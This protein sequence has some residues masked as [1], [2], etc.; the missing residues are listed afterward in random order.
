MDTMIAQLE[1]FIH[2]HQAWSGL[3][4]FLIAF[5]ESLV[6]VGLLIPATAAMVLIGGLIGTGVVGPVPVVVGA[7]LGAICGD[8]VSYV[9]GRKFGPGIVHRKPLRRYRQAVARTRLFFRKYGFAAVFLGRFL[10]PIRSTVPLVA[11]MM[12]MDQKRFQIAN[13]L[14]GA[15]WAPAMLAPGWVG[16]KGIEEMGGGMGSLVGP[17]VIV[18]IVT[19]IGTILGGRQLTRARPNRR[20]RASEADPA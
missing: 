16:A 5:G 19:I 2:T 11:G 7:I 4:V 6:L 1:Q 18:L 8:I 15:I 20:R 12:R 14:S 9:I 10:G 3:I 13:V 17:V